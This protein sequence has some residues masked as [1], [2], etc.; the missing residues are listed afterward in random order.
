MLATSVLVGPVQLVTGVRVTEASP[1]GDGMS[2]VRKLFVKSGS[3]R[4]RIAEPPHS[5]ENG[6]ADKAGSDD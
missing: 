1:K 2:R 5:R 4:K 3:L 6:G